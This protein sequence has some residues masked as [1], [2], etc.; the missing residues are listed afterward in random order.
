MW[1]LYILNGKLVLP[2][3]SFRALSFSCPQVSLFSSLIFF[4]PLH[5]SFILLHVHECLLQLT[6]K[7][8]IL[9][10][11]I[12]HIIVSGLN[13]RTKQIYVKTLLVKYVVKKL[14]LKSLPSL[15]TIY[16]NLL[17]NTYLNKIKITFAQYLNLLIKVMNFKCFIL[18]YSLL[19]KISRE[20]IL[21]YLIYWHL[22]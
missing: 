3:K 4:D 15:Q 22:N 21:S 11:I 16:S 2:P 6:T 8:N 14:S 9:L 10:T 12:S 7:K 13:I 20:L 19:S 17:I 5:L 18:S 1:W